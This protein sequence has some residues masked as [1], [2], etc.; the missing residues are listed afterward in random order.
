[1]LFNYFFFSGLNNDEVIDFVELTR[2]KALDVRFIEYMPFTGNKWD[3]DKF[4]S[5]KDMLR[6]I[7]RVHSDFFPL[8]NGPND[9]SKVNSNV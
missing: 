8:P 1:M 3:L 4:V 2:E 6:K 7:T 5:Y 9:T